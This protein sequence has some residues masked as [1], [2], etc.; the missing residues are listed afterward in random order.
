MTK[1]LAPITGPDVPHARGPRAGLLATVAA[2]GTTVVTVLP[3]FLVGGLSVQLY[4]DIGL[5]ALTL[6]FV[7]AVYWATSAL[8]S[9]LAG[10]VAGW[11]GARPTMILAV[12]LG[13]AALVGMA[14]GTPEWRWLFPWLVLAGAANA[15]GHPSSNALI[16]HKVSTRNRAFAFGL[17][18]AAIPLATLS[19]GLAVPLLATTIGWR[20]TF[21]IAGTVAA[22]VIVVLLVI[23]PRGVG[24]TVRKRSATG[25]DA[26][27]SPQLMRFLILASLASGLGSAQ[28]NVIGAFTVSSAT[29]TG[30]APATAGLIL[31]L[32]SVAGVIARPLAGVLADRGIG[33]SMATVALMLSS[34][35][36]GLV[37]MAIGIPWT[38][39]L[40]C[41]L[42]FGLGWGWNGLLHYVV[43]HLSHPH[44]GRATGIVQA[45]AYIGSAAGPFVFGFIFHEFGAGIGWTAAA[46][47]AALAALV[48]SAAYRLQKKLTEKGSPA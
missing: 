37:G 15:L 19:A 12:V 36:L 25:G 29:E 24:V 22:L 47:L 32:G 1:E 17:K 3:V 42:A 40:G 9:P 7:V 41:V 27:L 5:T 44:S 10:R 33:G 14:S 30:F 43:S 46:V 16:T 2:V 20:W 26:D 18:Q 28:A 6:G 11:W 38:F 35:A 4:S 39:A 21:A 13:G 34:G 31:G 45:G 8:F 48:A 23:V